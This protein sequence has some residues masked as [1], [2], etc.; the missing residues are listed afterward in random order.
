MYISE[1][2]NGRYCQDHFSYVEF[3]H[4]LWQPVLELAEESEEIT[5]TV[6]IH[7]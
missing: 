1:V 3:G 6:V 5:T 2:V 4:V 7:N